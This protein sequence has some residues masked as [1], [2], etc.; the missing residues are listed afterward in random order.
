MGTL[1]YWVAGTPSASAKRSAE[2]KMAEQKFGG[3]PRPLGSED[4]KCKCKKVSGTK[5]GGTKIGGI[6]IWWEPLAIGWQGPP[7]ASA[8]RSA[9]Q[10]MVEQK[11]V[12]LKLAELKL[13]KQ[14]FG[15]D[16]QP[17]GG[18]DPLV[19]VQKGHQ[20]KKWWN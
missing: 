3:D 13:A 4:P 5:N 20:N 18:S 17:L 16:P 12:E 7:S 9:E 1:G 19:L 8:K 10:K 11:M 15:G 14:K 2:Q 6:K